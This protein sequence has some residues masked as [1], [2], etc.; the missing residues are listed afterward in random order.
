MDKWGQSGAVLGT[1]SGAD[2][3]VGGQPGPDIRGKGESYW[4]YNGTTRGG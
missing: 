2:V 4:D 3:I 1:Q